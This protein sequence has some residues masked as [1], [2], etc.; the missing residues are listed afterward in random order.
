MTDISF[1]AVDCSSSPI[2]TQQQSDKCD[3]NKKVADNVEISPRFH[4]VNVISPGCEIPHTRLAGEDS[5]HSSWIY[6][7]IISV[8]HVVNPTAELFLIRKWNLAFLLRSLAL[9][10]VR[11]DAWE[12]IRMMI[13]WRQLVPAHRVFVLSMGAGCALFVFGAFKTSLC[14]INAGWLYA[15][16]RWC[17]QNKTLS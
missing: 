14:F 8:L 15:V 6:I 11:N 2:Q 17:F 1:H 3:A 7:T 10:F 13:I 4:P 5:R 12:L 9:L 16:C